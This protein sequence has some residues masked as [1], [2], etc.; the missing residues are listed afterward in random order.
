MRSVRLCFLLTVFTLAPCLCRWQV[1]LYLVCSHFLSLSLA[2]VPSPG[3]SYTFQLSCGLF[4]CLSASLCLF[5]CVL[6]CLCTQ[7]SIRTFTGILLY[8]QR[9]KLLIPKSYQYD[10]VCAC[11]SECVRACVSSLKPP[12]C[13]FAVAARSLD[14]HGCS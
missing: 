2:C 1:S 13:V 8:L 6:V 9:T 14:Y 3:H 10:Q 12:K 7:D 4:V 5:L 11:V